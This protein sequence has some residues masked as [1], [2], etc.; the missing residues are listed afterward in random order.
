LAARNSHLRR[1]FEEAPFH[2][3]EGTMD[4]ITILKKDHHAIKSLF[5]RYE[6]AGSDASEEKRALA[7]QILNDVAV[8]TSLEEQLFY[9]VVRELSQ[10]LREMVLEA[11][12]EHHAAKVFLSE[13]ESST[14]LDERFEADMALLIAC[15]RRHLA[16]EETNLFPRVRTAMNRGA[17]LDLGEALEE[18][19]SV[20]PRLADSPSPDVS[21][22]SL[23]GD[24]M[25]ILLDSTTTMKQ[26]DWAWT[27]L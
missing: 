15:V 24:D 9:P 4:A 23:E 3:E 26:G 13:L 25:E 12:E 22:A 17:L 1:Q 10:P 16:E 5:S 14:F 8:H 11:L 19:K 2:L 6:S 18:A 20:A 7:Q 21:A 27:Q